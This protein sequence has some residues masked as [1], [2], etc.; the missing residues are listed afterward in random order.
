MNM[1]AMLKQAQKLQNDML[2]SQEEIH[3]MTFIGKSSM[4]SVTING[5]GEVIDV[6]FDI[7]EVEK[8]DIEML[9]DASMLAFNDAK[10]QLDKVT[11]EKMGA[12][13]K[14]MPGLF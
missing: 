1:Q 11:E 14:G 8:D 10:K 12:Y 7:E 2:K 6:K 13:T 5:K 9:Q 4:V 3:S